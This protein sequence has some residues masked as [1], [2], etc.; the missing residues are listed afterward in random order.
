MQ[1]NGQKHL[2]EPVYVWEAPV[3][4]Y[5]WLNAAA[6]I[7]LFVT[8][9]YIGSPVMK[10]YG[11]PTGNFV[12]GRIGLLHGMTAYIFTANLLFRAYWSLVGNE[13]AHFRPWRRGFFRDG[14]DTIRYYLFL[15]KEHSLDLGHNVMAQLMYF[16]IMWFGS[17]IMIVTGFAMRGTMQPGGWINTGFGWISGLMGSASAVRTLHHISAWAFVA[18]VIGHVYMVVRQDIL[19]E[20]GTVSSIISGYKFALIK[21]ESGQED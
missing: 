19:D 17:F 9:M 2:K 18:F 15:K 1:R 10:P 5:H 4:I 6:I 3:R 11:E 12:M 7:V 21:R 13:F 20:D 16:F 14:Y 8:G